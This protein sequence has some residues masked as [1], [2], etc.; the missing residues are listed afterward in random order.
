MKQ[1]D[2][3]LKQWSGFW[4]GFGLTWLSIILHLTVPYETP[5]TI[6]FLI[7]YATNYR[8]KKN[9]ENFNLL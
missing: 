5:E 7:I 3:A 9:L 8:E 6:L 1:A 2:Q 4:T